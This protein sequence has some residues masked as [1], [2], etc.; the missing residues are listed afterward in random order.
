MPEIVDKMYG[1]IF[2]QSDK[3]VHDEKRNRV[4]TRKDNLAI[5]RSNL[6]Y[7]SVFVQYSTRGIKHVCSLGVFNALRWNQNMLYQF[8]QIHSLIRFIHVYLS[9]CY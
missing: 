2:I 4:T 1:M 5:F 8:T 6:N 9:V 7:I 3:L